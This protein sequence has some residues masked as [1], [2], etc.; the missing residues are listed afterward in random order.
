[1]YDITN[2]MTLY[3]RILSTAYS[4]HVLNWKNPVVVKMKI[5]LEVDPYSQQYAFHY[6][7]CIMY[8]FNVFHCKHYKWLPSND[9]DNYQSNFERF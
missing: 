5:K 3:I 8:L 2:T 4:S 1:M 6:I 7:P 9:D